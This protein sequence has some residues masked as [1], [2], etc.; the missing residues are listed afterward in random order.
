VG[1]VIAFIAD[2]EAVDRIIIY[3]QFSFVA[4]KPLY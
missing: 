1:K 3:P 4:D 2:H